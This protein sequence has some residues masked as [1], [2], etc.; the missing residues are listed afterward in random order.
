MPLLLH[1]RILVINLLTKTKVL[2]IS[3]K[4][5]SNWDCLYYSLTFWLSL[6]TEVNID[7]FQNGKKVYMSQLKSEYLD[8]I[9]KMHDTHDEENECGEDQPV[10][11]LNPNK[12]RLGVSSDGKYLIGSAGPWKFSFSIFTIFFSPL[13]LYMIFYSFYIFSMFCSC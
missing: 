1:W 3:T 8:W 4:L 6:D 11:V 12:K 2:N 9:C 13:K 10:I 7:I 5:R